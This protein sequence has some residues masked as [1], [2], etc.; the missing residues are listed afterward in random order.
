[1]KRLFLLAC[2]LFAACSSPPPVAVEVPAEPDAGVPPTAM[3]RLDSAEWL[4][5]RG[6]WGAWEREQSP[7]R[8]AT[9][10]Q[11]LGAAAQRHGCGSLP[12]QI[13]LD[14]GEIEAR[15]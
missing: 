4:E 8:L 5:L 1:M 12:V 3:A 13:H 10:Q 11:A 15:R 9:L 6:L 14:T 7:A 2:L